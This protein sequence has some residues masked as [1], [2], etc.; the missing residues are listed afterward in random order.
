M[1]Q[2]VMQCISVRCDFFEKY[3]SV[4]AE[5]QGE[6]DQ[7]VEK[8]KALG[9]TSADAAAFEAA[10]A[11]KGMQEEMNALLMRCTPR[12]YQ[13]TKEEKTAAKE[14]AKEIFKEDRSR[15]MK[16]AA[17]DVVDHA[18]VMAEEELHAQSRKAM[19]EMGIYDEYTRASNAIDMAKDPVGFFK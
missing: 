4:P 9:E 3:Y 17:A 8:L 16:E 11:A 1:D 12:P 15:I 10:F 2:A 19:I 14:T 18:A 13:M 7:F 6:V 5:V